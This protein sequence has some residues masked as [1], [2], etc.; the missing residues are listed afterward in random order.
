[1]V[2]PNEAN[3]LETVKLVEDGMSLR[4]EFRSSEIQVRQ[5]RLSAKAIL[6]VIVKCAQ[7]IIP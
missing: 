2:L 1:M 7:A 5:A 3:K 6:G 4:D